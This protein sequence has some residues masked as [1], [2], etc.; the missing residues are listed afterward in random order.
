MSEVPLQCIERRDKVRET[1]NPETQTLNK[2][3]L[4]IDT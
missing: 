1:L 2:T 3:K 4:N